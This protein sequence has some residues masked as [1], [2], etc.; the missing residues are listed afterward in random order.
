MFWLRISIQYG[1]F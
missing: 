1:M